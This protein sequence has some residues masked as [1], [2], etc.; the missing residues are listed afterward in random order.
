MWTKLLVLN[1]SCKPYVMSPVLSEQS[2]G[3]QPW[4]DIGVYENC[5][6]LAS[7]CT[8][9][10]PAQAWNSRIVN[11]P[12]VSW[13]PIQAPGSYALLELLGSKCQV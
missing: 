9:N 5:H 8:P 13:L 3:A 11:S 7:K 4:L 12:V 2:C 10:T 1:S 6:I